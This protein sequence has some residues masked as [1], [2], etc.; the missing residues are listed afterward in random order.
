MIRDHSADPDPYAEH[1]EESIFPG[2]GRRVSDEE[3]EAALVAGRMG[4]TVGDRADPD[5]VD[6]SAQED[7]PRSDEVEEQ[8]REGYRPD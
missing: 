8:A 3:R 5:G 2:A 6:P 1:P 7:D 4:A